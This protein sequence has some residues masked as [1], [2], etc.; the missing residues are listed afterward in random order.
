[1]ATL[2][3]KLAEEPYSI[4]PLD[5]FDYLKNF[6]EIYEL[7]RLGK[8]NSAKN[9]LNNLGGN[10]SIFP[11]YLKSKQED[12]LPLFNEIVKAKEA[13][14]ILKKGLSGG[15]LGSLN[16]AKTIMLS[17]DPDKVSDEA[18]DF[19]MDEGMWSWIESAAKRRLSQDDDE[20]MIMIKDSVEDLLEKGTLID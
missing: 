11:E 8:L 6:R 17:I 2:I 4:S 19:F 9:V 3:S 13:E 10:Y 12:V 18:V 7:L 1:M 16:R 15:M 5:T 14:D 20:A